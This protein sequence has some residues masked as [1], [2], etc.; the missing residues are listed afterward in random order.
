MLNLQKEDDEEF[1]EVKDFVNEIMKEDLKME[2]PFELITYGFTMMVK[3]EQ[4]RSEEMQEIGQK[5]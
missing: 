3:E 1:K 2:T 5:I 4:E